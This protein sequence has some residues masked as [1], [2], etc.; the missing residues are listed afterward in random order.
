MLNAINA[1]LEIIN[2]RLK[3]KKKVFFEL[4]VSLSFQ[5]SQINYMIKYITLLSLLL[6][7][8]FWP[9]FD[10]KAYCFHGCAFYHLWAGGGLRANLIPEINRG[11]NLFL[12]HIRSLRPMIM[13][14]RLKL[15]IY[16]SP[17]DLIGIRPV[18]L[19]PT[20]KTVK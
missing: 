17:C 20:Y 5:R 7:H 6:A 19:E 10:W 4:H 16:Y 14:S 3:G 12:G 9:I 1:R 8:R 2:S 18:S 15:N 13:D 11:L